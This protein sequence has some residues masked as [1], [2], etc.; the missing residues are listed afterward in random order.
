VDDAGRKIPGRYAAEV[1]RFYEV[2]APWL[3]GHALIRVQRD[4]EFAAA[5]ELAADLVQD[6]FEAAALAWETLRGLAPVQQRAWL[7]TTLSHKETSH[8]RRWLV[9]RRLEREL[10]RRHQAAEPD[11]EQQA[12]AGLALGRAAKIIENLPA[13]QR[14]IALMKWN[15]HMTEPEIARE[16]GCSKATVAAD[17]QKIRRT[18]IDGLGP[19]YP[20]AADDGE[21][22]AS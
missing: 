5:R 14:S 3:F 10:Q 17:V 11:P 21:G 20:F 16:L 22:E 13:R 19:Y 12:L 7:R 6:T 18:L 9:F 15:D 4:R 1:A 2:H 8:F